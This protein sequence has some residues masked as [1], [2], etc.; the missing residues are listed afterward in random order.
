MSPPAGPSSKSAR[1]DG[2]QTGPSSIAVVD[3][4][5]TGRRGFQD[6]VITGSSD[7]LAPSVAVKGGA[8]SQA[9][10]VRKKG[11]CYNY[12]GELSVD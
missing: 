7:M 4:T 11:M 6:R 2:E 9:G 1:T 5:G 3:D 8:G 10:Y 12:H